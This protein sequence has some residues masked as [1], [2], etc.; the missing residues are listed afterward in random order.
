MVYEKILCKDVFKAVMCHI[1]RAV[2]KHK[3]HRIEKQ[4]FIELL[5][6][7]QLGAVVI[8]LSVPQGAVTLE[9]RGGLRW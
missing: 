7:L 1:I 3:R 2:M 4:R 5:L 9:H 6:K 8:G